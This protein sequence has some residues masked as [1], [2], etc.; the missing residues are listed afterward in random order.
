MTIDNLSDSDWQG[1]FSFNCLNPVRSRVYI[2]CGGLDD[3]PT[4]K[5]P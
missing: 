4:R 5:E 2:A 3:F 1:V